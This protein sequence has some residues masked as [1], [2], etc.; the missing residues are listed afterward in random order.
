MR[1]LCVYCVCV[2]THIVCAFVCS[3]CV[4]VWV[5][6]CVRLCVSWQCLRVGGVCVVLPIVYVCACACVLASTKGFAMHG[7]ISFPHF[8][9]QQIKRFYVKTILVGSVCVLAV[10]A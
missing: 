9:W 5:L 7:H 3:L 4:F 2:C 6:L 1:G 8:A 10:F